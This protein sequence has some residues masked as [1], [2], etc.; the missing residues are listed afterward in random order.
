MDIGNIST[1]YAKAL[2]R[3][4]TENGEEAQVYEE[5]S[6]L[7]DNFS[8]VPELQKAMLN[9]VVAVDKKERLLHIACASKGQL[10]ASSKRFIRLLLDKDRSEMIMFVANSYGTVYRRVKHIVKARLILPCKTDKKLIDRMRRMVKAKTKS[11]IHFKV[12]EDPAIGGGFI[13]EYDTYR[14]DASVRNQLAL[15]R[16]ELAG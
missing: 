7:A 5:M 8:A 1:R 3:F 9:P 15:I 6:A 4:A 2:L 11:D 13:L 12:E 14:L 10:T 16:R